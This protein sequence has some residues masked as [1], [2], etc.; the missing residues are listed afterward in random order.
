MAPSCS[1]SQV[2]RSYKSVLLACPFTG[3]SR[4]FKNKSGLTK[5][6]RTQHTRASCNRQSFHQAAPKIRSP[7]PEA[8]FDYDHMDFGGPNPDAGFEDQEGFVPEDGS[9]VELGP[10]FR[11]FHSSLTSKLCCCCCHCSKPLKLILS[12]RTK[13]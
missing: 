6:T 3:C 11:V 2:S 7:S 5:H 4:M 1:R 13:M 8:R 9:W 12:Y 10:L